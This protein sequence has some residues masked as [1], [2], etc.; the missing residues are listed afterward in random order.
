[1]MV[2]TRLLID[3]WNRSIQNS[4]MGLFR[5][6]LL[7][8]A[9]G[10]FICLAVVAYNISFSSLET[11]TN[12][13][14]KSVDYT[15]IVVILLTTVTILFTVAAIF[16]ALLAVLGFNNIKVEA[17]KFAKTSAIDEIKLA[18]QEDG[19]ALKQIQRELQNEGPLRD[20]IRRQIG[21]DVT[22]QLALYSSIQS[23]SA[24]I[25]EDD[26]ADEGEQD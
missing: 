17:G 21:I 23:T 5:A 16:L 19:E 4:A 8:F 12:S 10:I 9:A 20:W 25:D 18:F 11:T 3:F 1:M 24:A 14:L 6:A 26:P 13:G 15:N 2:D 7:F 22:E